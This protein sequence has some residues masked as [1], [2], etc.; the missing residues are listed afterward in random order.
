MNPVITKE[1]QTTRLQLKLSSPS[2]DSEFQKLKTQWRIKL[3]DKIDLIAEELAL[4]G[5]CSIQTALK[6]D[7]SNPEDHGT[8]SLELIDPTWMYMKTPEA[9]K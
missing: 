9:K 6:I 3:D 8:Q 5:F 4:Y 1:Q 7:W 2:F